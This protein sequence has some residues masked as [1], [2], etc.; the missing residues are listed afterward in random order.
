MREGTPHCAL[1]VSRETLSA[2][3][4]RLLP[5]TDA[6][7]IALHVPDCSFCQQ[8]LAQF[9]RIAGAIGQDS[10]PDLRAQTWRGLQAR[11]AQKGHRPMRIARAVTIGGISATALLLVMVIIFGFI[12]DQR[13]GGGPGP[14]ATTTVTVTP[15]AF[16]VTS[17]DLAVT[18]KTIAGQACGSTVNFTYTAT[19]HIP[20]D[21]AGGTIQFMYTTTNGRGSTPASVT[22]PAGATTATYAFAKSGTLAADHTF[23]GIAE[24]SATSPNMI[25]SP[26]VQ[27]LGNCI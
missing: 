15:T 26:Q 13:P 5:E 19:F 21:T 7:A 17:V 8:R 20:A 24:V 25:N 9:T 27:P 1:G 23:P 10:A 6:H 16:V 14:G 18:P 12:L 11:I 3:R 22:V 4:D 2:W